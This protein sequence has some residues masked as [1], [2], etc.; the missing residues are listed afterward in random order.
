VGVGARVDATGQ[1]ARPMVVGLIEGPGSDCA[2][3]P[4]FR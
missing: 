2:E 4:V 3:E 1:M